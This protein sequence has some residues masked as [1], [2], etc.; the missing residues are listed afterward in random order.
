M[1]VKL[2]AMTCGRLTGDLGR[3]MEGG[4][5]LANLPIPAYLIEHPR[6]TVLF[7]TGLHPD[8]Q[9][10]PAARVGTRLTGLF[11]FDFHPGESAPGSRR[12]AATRQRSTS[13]ST[14]IFTST[15][16]AATC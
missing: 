8:C 13:S 16:S 3:L 15:M 10:D 6:G 14:R 7:D 1:S 12:S 9:H 11:S 4:E 2:F 5:G